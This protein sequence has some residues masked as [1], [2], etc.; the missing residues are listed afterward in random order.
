MRGQI[1]IAERNVKQN[2]AGLTL[3]DIF[4]MELQ[5][6]WPAE[7]AGWYAHRIDGGVH[8]FKWCDNEHAFS[9]RYLKTL[10]N[11]GWTIKFPVFIKPKS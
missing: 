9:S 2:A 7:E 4:Y 10:I 6:L 5:K 1:A 11:H 3:D 8:E